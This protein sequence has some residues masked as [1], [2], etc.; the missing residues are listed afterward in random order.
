MLKHQSWSIQKVL[1]FHEKYEKITSGSLFETCAYTKD[2]SERNSLISNFKEKDVDAVG[3][4][5]NIPCVSIEFKK[6][7]CKCYK[8][9]NCRKCTNFSPITED[10]ECYFLEEQCGSGVTFGSI[11]FIFVI[12]SFVFIILLDI[13]PEFSFLGIIP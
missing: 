10:I 6:E 9:T 4:A 1:N 5:R 11:L 2:E 7:L 12:I 3:Y 13:I 8:H